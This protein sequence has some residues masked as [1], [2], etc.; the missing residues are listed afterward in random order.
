MQRLPDKV[1]LWKGPDRGLPYHNP[2]IAD[3]IARQWWQGQ[4]PEA[5]RQENLE[6]FDLSKKPL[7]SNMIALVCSAVRGGSFQV[8]CQ[9]HWTVNV[10][11]QRAGRDGQGQ[12]HLL[13]REDVRA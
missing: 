3:V 5:L 10:D 7:S 12:Y 11:T 13:R 9:L 1:Q 6:R 2:V 4:H 8:F